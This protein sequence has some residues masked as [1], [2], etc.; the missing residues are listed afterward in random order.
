[1]PSSLALD[2]I[3]P[4]LSELV[5]SVSPSVPA[6][7]RRLRQRNSMSASPT[8]AAS[9]A[10]VNSSVA[11]VKKR[12]RPPGSKNKKAPE[13]AAQPVP[14]ERPSAPAKPIAQERG[15]VP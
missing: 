2:T 15:G 3:L 5:D 13:Q 9:K 8:K 12:G 1:M 14:K 7:G 10:R 11:A 4:G 6:S